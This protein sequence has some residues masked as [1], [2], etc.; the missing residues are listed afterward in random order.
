MI[1]NAEA[2]DYLFFFSDVKKISAPDVYGTFNSNLSIVFLLDNIGE[3]IS[4]KGQKSVFGEMDPKELKAEYAKCS[5]GDGYYFDVES[6][7][8]LKIKIIKA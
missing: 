3:F 5:V 2:R 7:V 1:A 8:L 6:D 4:D